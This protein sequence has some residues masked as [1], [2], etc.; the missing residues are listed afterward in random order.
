MNVSQ[1]RKHCTSDKLRVCFHLAEEHKLQPLST[2]K[3]SADTFRDRSTGK[4]ERKHRPQRPHL[5][6]ALCGGLGTRAGTSPARP[7]CGE[8]W[9]T[10]TVL[11]GCCGRSGQG[12]GSLCAWGYC[13][14]LAPTIP[15]GPWRSTLLAE[16]GAAFFPRRCVGRGGG[17]ASGSIILDFVSK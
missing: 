16:G 15:W 1:Q 5:W 13:F 2:R 17:Q 11:V 12:P 3:L 7:C 4:A 6:A 8:A 10:L 9:S 14:L